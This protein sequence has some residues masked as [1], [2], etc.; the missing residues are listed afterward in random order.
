MWIYTEYTLQTAQT[1]WC[2]QVDKLSLIVWRPGAWWAWQA[3]STCI[4]S[5]QSICIHTVRWP[6]CL[7]LERTGVPPPY[8]WSSGVFTRFPCDKHNV[9][10]FIFW[11]S[12][13]ALQVEVHSPSLKLFSFSKHR[14]WS[15]NFEHTLTETRLKYPLQCDTSSVSTHTLFTW[16]CLQSKN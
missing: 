4:R 15:S 1:A 14:V 3:Y 13:R 11:R 5:I 9:P 2:N 8:I 10:R 12:S 7:K 16:H 6:N